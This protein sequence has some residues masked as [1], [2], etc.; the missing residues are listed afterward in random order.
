[1]RKNGMGKALL[2]FMMVILSGC[3]TDNYGLDPKRPQN[4]VVWN[5]YNGAQAIA[6]E[7]LVDD[8][9]NTVGAEQGIIVRSDSKNTVDELYQAIEDSVERKVG[10]DELPDIFPTYL[11]SAV[12][13]DEKGILAD[14]G[15]YITKEEQAEYVDSYVQEG[16]FGDDEAWKLF[17]VAK[18]TEIMI[19]NKTDWDK[20]AEAAG[21]DINDLATMEGLVEVAGKYYDYSGGESFFGRDAFANY[22]FSGSAELGKEIYTVEN[23]KVTLQFDEEVMQKLWDNYYVPYVKGYFKH[24]GRYRSDD[25]KM[26]EI[27]AQICSTSS[28]AYFPTEVTKDNETYPIDYL[29]LPVPTFEGTDQYVVQQGASMAVTK[30]TEQR[31][32][33][34]VVFLQWLTQEEQNMAFALQAG[35]L[36]VKKS[37]NDIERLREYQES[38]GETSGIEVD[39][40]NGAFEQL[41]DGTPYTTKGFDGAEK[42]RSVLSYSMLDLAQQDRE[43]ILNADSLEKQKQLL[44]DCLG[45]E[46]FEAW[47]NETKDELLQICGE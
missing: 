31:E 16:Y 25:I 1:M 26:G 2:L 32:Y 23:G 10:A 22:M 15:Q 11:D 27:I 24:V 20:F 37:A 14:L 8:F 29:V 40:I 33:A 46:H 21:A 5:Y 44:D 18:S 13:L 4:I 35:Y 34:S 7:K 3:G 30:S 9:N 39:I 43:A 41:A 6:F 19:L 47:Y 12:T 45:A 17:P 42:V 36:P 38:N 28:A